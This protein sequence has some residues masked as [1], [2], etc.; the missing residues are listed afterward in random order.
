MQLCEVEA[1]AHPA[2]WKVESDPS[3]DN[4]SGISIVDSEGQPVAHSYGMR[5]DMMLASHA[6][7]MLSNILTALKEE[8]S[9]VREMDGCGRSCEVC[10]LIA[11]AEEVPT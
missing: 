4:D 1:R 7:N 6:R 11:E 10:A 5:E 8:H 2:P 9:K 3:P